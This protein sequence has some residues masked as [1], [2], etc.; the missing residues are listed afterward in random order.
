MKM[1]NKEWCDIFHTIVPASYCNFLLIDK[2]WLNFI[3]S[4]GLNSPQIAKVYA[5]R[6]L[7]EFLKDLENW[8]KPY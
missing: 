3:K 2:R 1:P 6:N 8:K 4:T 7:S 5:Q